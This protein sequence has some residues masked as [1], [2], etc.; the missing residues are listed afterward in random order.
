MLRA[1]QTKPS[2]KKRAAPSTKQILS[3][4]GLP[5][6][7]TQTKPATGKSR[8]QSQ[9]RLETLDG[10]C[11]KTLNGP[12]MHKLKK[13]IKQHLETRPQHSGPDPFFNPANFDRAG[14]RL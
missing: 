7:A 2:R 14:P 8:R 1:S 6:R 10:P 11:K 9:S 4:M 3:A 5:G 13:R 12:I